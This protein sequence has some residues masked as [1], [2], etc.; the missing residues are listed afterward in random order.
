MSRLKRANI[1]Y[2]D[3]PITYL[4]PLKDKKC[5][6]R[7]FAWCKKGEVVEDFVVVYRLPPVL[8]FYN[9]YRWINKL[10]QRKIA[11]YVR[12]R[13]KRHGFENPVLWCYSPMSCDAVENIPHSALVYDCVDR[14]SAY[15]GMIDVATV[16]AMERDL[17]TA[18][19]QVFCTASG[20]AETLS[21]YNE[22]TIML[23]NG[24]KFEH[25]NSVADG[26]LPIP[27]DVKDLP[28]PIIGFSGML[29]ECIDYDAIEEIAKNRPEWSVVLVGGNMPGVNL[30]YLKKYPNIHFLGMKPYGEM[31]AYL[32]AFDVCLNVFRSGDL[33]KDVSPLKFFEYLATGK[34]VVST[35]QPEQVLDYADCVYIANTTADMVDMCEKALSETNEEKTNLRIK[36][37]K[38]CSW[39]ARVE[40]MENILHSKGIFR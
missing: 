33:S 30:D 8:P 36:Y 20:L 23:P 19:D 3:P 40:R 10:N 4:A 18:A 37:G 12:R 15:K 26:D 13:M 22:G 7:L 32:G 38:D 5:I 39:D 24:V 17:A 34:P 16:D 31:P 6:N 2:F 27:D 25:F 11:R 9:K 1:L 29:Q 14:H 35:P 28:R 21:K